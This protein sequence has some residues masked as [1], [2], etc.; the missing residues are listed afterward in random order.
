M[1]YENNRKQIEKVFGRWIEHK[2]PKIKN[3]SDAKSVSS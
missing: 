3:R 1:K 2:V